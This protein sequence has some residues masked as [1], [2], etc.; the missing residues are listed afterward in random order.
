MKAKTELQKKIEKMHKKDLDLYKEI[1]STSYEAAK[2][3]VIE[4]YGKWFK[5]GPVYFMIPK[6]GRGLI[7][8][9]VVEMKEGKYIAKIVTDCDYKLFAIMFYEKFSFDKMEEISQEEY[10]EA[11]DIFQNIRNLEKRMEK[12]NK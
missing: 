7:T 10:L 6:E 11:Q 12:F 5:S 2:E 9:F 3:F 1:V 4:N 8:R